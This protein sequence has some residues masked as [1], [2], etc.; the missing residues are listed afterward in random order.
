VALSYA[1]KRGNHDEGSVEPFLARFAV[2]RSGHDELPGR[3][4]S[5][6]HVWLVQGEDGSEVPLAGLPGGATLGVTVTKVLSEQTDQ[7]E[8]AWHA[9]T[10]PVTTVTAVEMEGTDSRTDVAPALWAA[11]ITEVHSEQTD[12]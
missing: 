12:K 8:V 1:E 3:Y 6:R 9:G 5:E 4:C 11:T 2:D 7:S 10:G